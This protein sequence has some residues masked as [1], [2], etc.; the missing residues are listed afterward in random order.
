FELIKKLSM[1]LREKMVDLLKTRVNYKT[2]SRKLGVTVTTVGAK[3]HEFQHD[4]QSTFR[5]GVPNQI[6]LGG[7]VD[8]LEADGTTV[9]K[10]TIAKTL[11]CN[12]LTPCSAHKFAKEHLHGLERD[13][14]KVLWS[15]ETNMEL[16][17][18]LTWRRKH[19]A[20]GCFSAQGYFRV[21][22]LLPST[23]WLKMGGGWTSFLKIPSN[24]CRNLLIKYKKS[25][26]SVLLTGLLTQY[27][28]LPAYTNS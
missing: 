28:I 16:W 23:T 14:E 25:L 6:S 26:S 19:Y 9:S 2:I 22:N 1:D 27:F 18:K 4:H 5:S 13:W 7:F 20:L 3:I 10:K 12:S 15:D 24:I 8:D 17:H 21:K 11:R